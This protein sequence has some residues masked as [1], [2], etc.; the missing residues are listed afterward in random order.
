MYKK[1]NIWR[2]STKIVTNKKAK[3]TVRSC[4]ITLVFA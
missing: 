2:L 4:T 3:I 1:N